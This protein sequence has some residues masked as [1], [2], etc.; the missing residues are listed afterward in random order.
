MLLV[1]QLLVAALEKVF[2]KHAGLRIMAGKVL[3]LFGTRLYTRASVLA[4]RSHDVNASRSSSYS[5]RNKGECIAG[6]VGAALMRAA[7]R[8]RAWTR[9][10]IA[11]RGSFVITATASAAAAA[12]AAAA[13]AQLTFVV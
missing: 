7:T 6:L 10:N 4:P 9:F 3:L 13:H 11:C 12:A 2:L 8:G 1:L 5:R